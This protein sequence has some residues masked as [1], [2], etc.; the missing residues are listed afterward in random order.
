MKQQS[1]YDKYYD[2]NIIIVVVKSAQKP[3]VTFLGI[4]LCQIED[5]YNK[6]LVLKKYT[7]VSGVVILGPLFRES[8]DANPGLKLIQVLIYLV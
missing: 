3:K 7:F 6:L 5:L 1:E 2:I 4:Y 8:I